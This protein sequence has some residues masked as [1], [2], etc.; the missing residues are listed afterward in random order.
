VATIS[1]LDPQLPNYGLVGTGK[2]L[3]PGEPS[4]SR[5]VSG[6]PVKIKSEAMIVWERVRAMSA[7]IIEKLLF[8]RVRVVFMI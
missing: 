3:R 4:L 5:H 6:K 1:G 7:L 2:S 8:T